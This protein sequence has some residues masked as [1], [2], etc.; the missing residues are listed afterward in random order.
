M[1]TIREWLNELP[2]DVRDKAIKNTAKQNSEDYFN[3]ISDTQFPSIK[4]MFIWCDTPEG[5][6]F[7]ENVNN[8]L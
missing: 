5:H 4:H 7:W 8:R 3:T 6:N 2:K 1:K